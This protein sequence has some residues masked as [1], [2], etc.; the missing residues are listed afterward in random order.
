M[1]AACPLAENRQWGKGAGHF[2]EGVETSRATVL[3]LVGCPTAGIILLQNTPQPRLLARSPRRDH[4]QNRGP[5][6]TPPTQG[7]DTFGESSFHQTKDWRRNVPNDL[8][9]EEYDDHPATG[10]IH[11]AVQFQ[12]FD[13]FERNSRHLDEIFRM[14][15]RIYLSYYQNI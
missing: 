13:K 10:L 1:F 14:Q 7:Q 6:S 12:E 9:R 8:N 3:R 2:P 4:Q 5:Q 11:N 15:P